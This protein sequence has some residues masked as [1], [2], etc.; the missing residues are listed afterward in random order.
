MICIAPMRFNQYLNKFKLKEKIILFG[1]KRETLNLKKV[2]QTIGGY[3][4]AYIASLEEM[5]NVPYSILKNEEKGSFYVWIVS[6]DSEKYEQKLKEI[7]LTKYEEYE[8]ITENPY[9]NQSLKYQLDVHLG[10]T[11]KTDILGGGVSVFGDEQAEN[12]LKIVVLGNSTSN[13]K[14][15]TFKSWIEAFY[16]ILSE[17]LDGK[18]SVVVYSAAVSGYKSAQEL[19]KLQRDMLSIKPDI[20]ISFSGVNDTHSNGGTWTNY[21][22]KQMF[23]CLRENYT[24][25]GGMDI[26]GAEYS[27]GVITDETP[28][29]KWLRNIR[30]MHS[31]CKEFGIQY[32]AFLQPMIGEKNYDLSEMIVGG[33]LKNLK[34]TSCEFIEE[35]RGLIDQYNYIYDIA[36]LFDEVKDIYMDTAHVVES[37]NRMIAEKIASCLKLG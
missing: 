27:E 37:G 28:A 29:K 20:V 13:P 16:E 30:L 31:A 23:D 33:D 8:S 18:K 10:Y 15:F 1:D 7:G 17:D 32:Y 11:L 21:Y 5:E 12:T 9:A 2:T 6:E 35:V 14:L 24:S 22:Q 26:S 3:E 4:I 25:L 19:I 34:K 36:D